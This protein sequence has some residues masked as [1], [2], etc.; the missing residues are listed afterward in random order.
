MHNVNGYNLVICTV[1]LFYTVGCAHTGQVLAMEFLETGYGLLTYGSDDTVRLWDTFTGA[2]HTQYTI[3]IS[4]EPF[5]GYT[6][7]PLLENS[8][9]VSQLR[10]DKHFGVTFPRSK[11]DLV[12]GGQLRK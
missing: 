8:V 9:T 11:H 7:L 5:A 10:Y 12:K 6:N 1:T 3:S 2:L 4:L